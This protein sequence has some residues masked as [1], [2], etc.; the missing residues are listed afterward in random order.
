[1]AYVQ[2]QFEDF[3]QEIRL[4]A[5]DENA[6]LREKR[7]R[8]LDKLKAGIER[9]RNAGKNIPAY[10]HFNQGSYAMQSRQAQSF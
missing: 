5:F 7:D 9:Q 8:I 10:T 1:M 6:T 3:D 2:K 4:G